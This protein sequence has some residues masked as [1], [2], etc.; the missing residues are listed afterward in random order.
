MGV[1]YYDCEYCGESVADCSDG[2]CSCEDCG[3][4]FCSDECVGVERDEDLGYHTSCRFCSGKDATESQL[5]KF[6]L[7]KLN[8]TEAELK[9]MYLKDFN[10]ESKREE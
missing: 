2:F 7:V 1:D 9:E 5:L 6:A 8:L 4:K 10:N 3:R